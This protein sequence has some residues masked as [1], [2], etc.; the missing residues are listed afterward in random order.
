MSIRSLLVLCLFAALS[1]AQGMKMSVNQLKGF[2]RSSIQLQHSDKQVA[3]YLKNVKLTEKLTP[4]DVDEL[5]GQGLG[6]RSIDALKA[7]VSATAALPEPARDPVII[8][9]PPPP[10]PPPSSEDQARIIAEAREMALSY[11]KRLPD[12]IC[13]QV[14]RRYVD[15]SG[16]EIWRLADTVA[17]RLSYFEQREDYKLISVNGQLSQTERDKLGGATSSGEFGSMLKGIFEPATE[18]EFQWERWAKLRGKIAHVYSYRVRQSRS[19]WLVSW[20]HQLEIVP[21]YKGLIYI[22]RDVPMVLRVTLEAETIPASF[23]IQEARTVLDYDFTDIAGN[24]FLLPLR[25]EMRM[26][27]S[28]FL[29]KNQVEFRSYRKFGAEATITFDT[30]AEPIPDEKL[31]E[32]TVTP[33]KPRKK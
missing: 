9:T 33:D 18:A 15:P 19:K 11:T 6:P 1:L 16:L 30:S 20:Q 14:T 5:I 25:S 12:F 2:L 22:D 3:D 13:L 4:A 28:K 10:M 23:P 21:G 17:E 31:R 27:E 7:M 24:Q 26:R 8:K 32:E 29:V